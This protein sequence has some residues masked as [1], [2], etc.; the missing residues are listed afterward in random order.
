M[1]VLDTRPPVVGAPGPPRCLSASVS[2]SQSSCFL[3]RGRWPRVLGFGAQHLLFICGQTC[4]TALFFPL[5][6]YSRPDVGAFEQGPLSDRLGS[7]VNTAPVPPKGE[8]ADRWLVHFSP[9]RLLPLRAPH[10]VT[11]ARG[12]DPCAPA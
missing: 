7:S 8:K 9:M 12:S 6:Q 4:C 2:S 3:W 5:T 10:R 11:P 1:R